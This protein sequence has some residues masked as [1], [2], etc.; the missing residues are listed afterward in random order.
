MHDDRDHV[1]SV[2]LSH[3]DWKEFVKLQPQPVGSGCA[4]GFRRRFSASRPGR[5]D[6]P[7]QLAS[8]WSRRPRRG[9][10]A[11]GT[12]APSPNAL[13]RY[14]CGCGSGFSEYDVRLITRMS[15][16]FTLTSIFRV[17]FSGSGIRRGVA[18]HVVVAR[19]V[20]DPLQRLVEV[21]LVDDGDAA[22]LVGQHA[23]AVLRLAH[24]LA[25]LHRIELLVEIGAG[26]Q[27]ARIDRVDRRVRAVGGPRQLAE[28][29]RQVG[30]GERPARD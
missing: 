27:P 19:L 15:G 5:R 1:I 24:V 16:R 30:V 2:V 7:R 12:V 14:F 22:G 29:A 18:Q 26:D 9:Y 25:E 11:S 3:E 23:Q 10:R 6:P 17:R 4:S 21:V 20:V 13:V 8:Q 28:L